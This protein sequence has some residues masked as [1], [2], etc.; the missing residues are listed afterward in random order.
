MCFY[1]ATK[2]SVMLIHFKQCLLIAITR[3]P[4]W[5]WQIIPSSFKD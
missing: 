2:L 5:R 1:F 4:V 3:K